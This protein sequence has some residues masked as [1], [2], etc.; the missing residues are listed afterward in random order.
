MKNIIKLIIILISY[1][2]YAQDPIIN[3]NNWHGETPNNCY[4]KYIDNLLNPFEGTW[5]YTN[6]NTSLK[7]VLLKKTMTYRGGL[8]EDIL[9]GEYQYIRDGEE[10]FNSLSEIDVVLPFQINHHIAG[11]YLPKTPTPFSDYTTDNFRVNL[12][13]REDNGFGCNIEVRKTSVDGVEA[14]QIFKV[15]RP[16]LRT[17]GIDY[18]G[19]AMVKDGFYT[20]VKLP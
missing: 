10:L 3:I 6:G 19:S 9:I 16:P 11:N 7:I 2:S 18:P 17:N 8:Y 5:V 20:L 15:S 1:S 4:L 13:F 12:F 14:I